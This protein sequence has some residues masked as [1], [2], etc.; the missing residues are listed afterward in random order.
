ML[1]CAPRSSGAAADKPQPPRLPLAAFW[2]VDLEVQ[3]AAPPVSDG[4][5]VFVAL[6]GAHLTARST[7]DGHEVWRITKDVSGPMAAAEGLVFISAGDAIEAVNGSDGRNA[8]TV[9]R[10]KTAAPLVAKDGWVIAVTGEEI[11]AIRAKDGT[12]VWRHA[13]GGVRLPPG[14]DGDRV[15]TGA[16]DG[17]VLALTLATGAD[18]WDRYLPGGVTTLAAKDGR[19]YAGAGDKQL[20]CL[21]GRSGKI[22]WSWSIGSFPTGRIAVDDQRVYVA[23]L[24]NVVYALDRSNGNQRWT[25]AVRRRPSG[26]VVAGH[27]VFVPVIA[28]ELALFYDDNGKPS[29]T[30]VLPDEIPRDLPPDIRETA[31][32]LNVFVITGSLKNEWRLTFL[33]PVGETS[34]VPIDKLDAMPGVPFLTDPVLLPIGRLLGTLVLADPPLQP[35]STIDWPVDLRDPPL[36]PL[37][38]FPGLQLR[39][40]SP[41]LP[42]RRAP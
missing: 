35:F 3:A 36:L 13:A 16:E 17:R 8:W 22:S 33:A 5:H 7:A 40:L 18:V 32:G 37:T 11:L 12:V 31:A 42:T 30:I 20:H 14:I 38:S 6:K 10:V 23:A 2:S 24:N 19:I 28:P 25:A 26:V 41:V 39:P 34:I 27:V 29:G 4:D 15:Y 9:P 1:V 21:D